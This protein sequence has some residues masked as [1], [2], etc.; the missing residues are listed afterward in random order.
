MSSIINTPKND[1]IAIE[2]PNTA[3]SGGSIRR[4]R[5]TFYVSLG[6]DSVKSQTTKLESK[7]N[8]P[9]LVRKSIATTSL[10][11]SKK[12]VN[13][14]AVESTKIPLHQTKSLQ[15]P[16]SFRL[17][18]GVSVIGG[19]TS[20]SATFCGDRPDDELP[21]TKAVVKAKT[22]EIPKPQTTQIKTVNKPS[23]PIRPPQCSE[24]PTPKTKSPLLRVSSKLLS[25]SVQALEALSRNSSGSS[26]SVAKS[27]T[28]L[29]SPLSLIRKASSRKLSRSSSNIV[30]RNSSNRLSSKQDHFFHTD[31]GASDISTCSI[32]QIDEPPNDRLLA[33]CMSSGANSKLSN[34]FD[35]DAVHSGMS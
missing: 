26:E 29:G 31:A 5:S 9:P 1:T 16:R 35:E 23:Q 6:S 2:D 14:T 25:S 21:V 15:Q 30:T 17:K 12:D 33:R 24:E 13:K 7:R 18:S 4:R 27:S 34:Q 28:G 10:D 19:T 3:S 11:A 22:V 32:I 20:K 8:H